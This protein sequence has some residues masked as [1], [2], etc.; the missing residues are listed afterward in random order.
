M[1]PLTIAALVSGGLNLAKG[2]FGGF[3]TSRA[4]RQLKELR[5]NRPTY[6]IPEAAQQALGLSQQMAY[7][8]LPGRSYL[9]DRLGRTTA[10]GV[11]SVG[12]M[13]GSTAQAL[14]AVTDIYGRQQEAERDIGYQAALWKQQAMQN[15]QAQLGQMAGYQEQ[16]FNINQWIPYQTEMNR[17]YEQRM[18]GQQNLWGGLTGVANTAMGYMGAKAQQGAMEGMGGNVG[19]QPM[20][21]QPT[22]PMNYWGQYMM[23]NPT[24]V[25]RY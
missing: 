8:D 21:S 7:S 23:Q 10:A 9:E 14:G 6:E 24:N 13:A 11:R 4:S 12:R 2:L 3:Q 1:E 16:A 19:I 25:W 17:L 18:T 22:Q 5:R 20:V 15:Y